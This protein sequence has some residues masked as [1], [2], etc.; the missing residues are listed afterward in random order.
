MKVYCYANGSLNMKPLHT[1]GEF[2]TKG[3]VEIMPNFETL[4]ELLKSN[5]A[6]E[7][8][9]PNLQATA[10]LTNHGNAYV[11]VCRDVLGSDD[12]GYDN[13]LTFMKTRGDET[14]ILKMV[15]MWKDGTIDLSSMNF[16]QSIY[17]MNNENLETEVLGTTGN[18]KKLKDLLY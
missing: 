17:E 11:A 5:L 12:C 16:I 9:A 15:T 4:L 13:M 3:M 18:V 7:T 8:P 1:F 6:E 14:R 10:L 2:Q